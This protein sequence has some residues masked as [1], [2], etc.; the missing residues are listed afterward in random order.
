MSKG[1][2]RICWKKKSLGSHENYN[3]LF[4]RTSH[5]VDQEG[6]K[7]VKLSLHHTICTCGLAHTVLRYIASWGSFLVVVVLCLFYA[8]DTPFTLQTGVTV[9]SRLA[10]WELGS[11]VLYNTLLQNGGDFF[12]VY[13]LLFPWQGLPVY[14]RLALNILHSSGWPRACHHNPTSISEVL[15]YRNTQPLMVYRI[16]SIH[17]QIGRRVKEPLN[18]VEAKRVLGLIR[19]VV[20]Q[21]VTFFLSSFFFFYVHISWIWSGLGLTVCPRL[22]GTPK[23]APPSASPMLGLQA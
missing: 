17:K 2:F 8:T 18:W 5:Y 7:L 20:F 3:F 19:I 21:S 4:E 14:F 23:D 11:Q 1:T 16:L 9:E 15:G 22:P 10:T 6:L 13:F 12:F